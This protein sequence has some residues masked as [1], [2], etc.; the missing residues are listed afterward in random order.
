MKKFIKLMSLLLSF[1][2]IVSLV[3]ACAKDKDNSGEPV[4]T[5]TQS[6]IPAATT[7]TQ[8]DDTPAATTTQGSGSNI[9]YADV[10]GAYMGKAAIKGWFDLNAAMILKPDGSYIYQTADADQDGKIQYSEEGTFAIN[11]N[12]ITFT[13]NAEGATPVEGTFENGSI[14]AKLRVGNALTISVTI[15]FDILDI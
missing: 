13:P 10:A 8:G 9:S 4:N 2:F 1:L 7:T 14:K 3:V 15:T 11:G 6:N 5:T 12:K